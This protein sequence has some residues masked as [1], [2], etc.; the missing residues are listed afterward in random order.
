LAPGGLQALCDVFGL[1]DIFIAGAL[2]EQA[3]G[4]FP[5]GHRHAERCNYAKDAVFH[6]GRAGTLRDG[7]AG[8]GV[9]QGLEF[10]LE[11]AIQLRVY[12][13]PAA[14]AAGFI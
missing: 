9:V 10:L 13:G 3:S 11:G 7:H 8:S 5:D 12:P 14:H 6:R 2:E 1:L 4:N